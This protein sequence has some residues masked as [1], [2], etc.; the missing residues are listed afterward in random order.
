M[1]TQINEDLIADMPDKASDKLFAHSS[2]DWT[3]S[4]WELAQAIIA[5]LE[6]LEQSGFVDCKVSSIVRSSCQQRFEFL[7]LQW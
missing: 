1:K 6:V 7:A 3:P 5:A 4:D 2:F